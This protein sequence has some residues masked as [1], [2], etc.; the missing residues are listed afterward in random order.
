[1]DTQVAENT[2]QGNAH[3][4]VH[5]RPVK[6]KRGKRWPGVIPATVGGF[7]RALESHLGPLWDYA[8]RN[9]V[10]AGYPLERAFSRCRGLR[11]DGAESLLAVAVA[12]LYLADIRSGF[13]GR[14][15]GGGPWHR[16]TLRDIAQLAFGSQADA[17]LR[18][19]RRALDVLISLRFAFPTRQVRRHIDGEGFRSAPGVRRLNLDRI[20]R[21]TGT[22]WL[23]KRDRIEADRRKGDG[24]AVLPAAP[25][26][27][28]TA[29]LPALE[30]AA[31]SRR[32]RPGTTGDPPDRV[33]EM[34]ADLVKKLSR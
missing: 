23:L 31:R 18:R 1:M 11:E 29:P 33:G 27:D 21:L 26:V 15:A 5:W 28:K 16:Y 8:R 7:V 22:L 12:L 13:I 34:L 24:V 32:E 4:R 14:P 20:C 3:R 17:D 25:R 6:P 10:I 30:A 2:G 9:A 19:A